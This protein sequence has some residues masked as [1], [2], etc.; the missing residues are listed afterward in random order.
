MINFLPDKVDFLYSINIDILQTFPTVE[1]IPEAYLEQLNIYNKAFMRFSQRCPV[2][3]VLLGS[4]YA[5]AF[6]QVSP[7]ESILHII[8]SI[9]FKLA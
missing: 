6:I 1:L 4:N 9:H 5:S 8:L 3:D 7:I 2:V